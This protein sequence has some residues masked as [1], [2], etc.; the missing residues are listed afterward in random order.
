MNES[1]REVIVLHTNNNQK[2]SIRDGLKFGFGF[3]IGWCTARF[4]KHAIIAKSNNN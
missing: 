4:F 3:Y 1:N 2:L